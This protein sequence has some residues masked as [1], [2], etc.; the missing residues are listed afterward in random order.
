[1][2]V[3]LAQST[4]RTRRLPAYPLS[5]SRLRLKGY[6]RFSRAKGIFNFQFSMLVINN[7]RQ[8]IIEGFGTANQL[9]FTGSGMQYFGAT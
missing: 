9:Q 8:I 7:R 6:R 1:M 4:Q 3:S 5:C 2:V